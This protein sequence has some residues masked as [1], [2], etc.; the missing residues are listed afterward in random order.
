[1]SI[2]I[3]Y[4][5]EYACIDMSKSVVLSDIAFNQCKCLTGA[6]TTFRPD[7]KYILQAILRSGTAA[8]EQSVCLEHSGQLLTAEVL[9]LAVDADVERGSLLL[10]MIQCSSAGSSRVIGEVAYE[11]N[12]CTMTQIPNGNAMYSWK[13]KRTRVC[14]LTL[15]SCV[16][17]GFV[18]APGLAVDVGDALRAT[19]RHAYNRSYHI[20]QMS[21]TLP[22]PLALFRDVYRYTVPEIDSV[23]FAEVGRYITC[24][25]D[26]SIPPSYVSNLWRFA[27]AIT[28]H[29]S[30]AEPSV[31]QAGVAQASVAEPSVPSA[32]VPPAR[33]KHDWD[34]LC[35]MLRLDANLTT[36]GAD[37]TGTG[38]ASEQWQMTRGVVQALISAG[39]SDR[40]VVSDCEDMAMSII[41]LAR[42]VSALGDQRVANAMEF[43][44]VICAVRG[45]KFEASS[46]QIDRSIDVRKRALLED[47]Q[48][49]SGCHTT[50]VAISS[51]KLDALM[52][53]S[54]DRCIC[55]ELPDKCCFIDELSYRTLRGLL[56]DSLSPVS[57]GVYVSKLADR[58]FR[59][60][61]DTETAIHI[62]ETKFKQLGGVAGGTLAVAEVQ[63]ITQL[64]RHEAVAQTN[65]DPAASPPNTLLEGT[66]LV[67]VGQTDHATTAECVREAGRECD[68]AGVAYE[69]M[70]CSTGVPYWYRAAVMVV[71]RGNEYFCQDRETGILGV[72]MATLLEDIG[73]VSLQPMHRVLSTAERA[74][75]RHRLASIL[76]RP[77]LSELDQAPQAPPRVEP[78]KWVLLKGPQTDAMRRLPGYASFPLSK[79]VNINFM[80]TE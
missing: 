34:V 32:G 65:A 59:K 7:A 70:H 69:Y 47:W 20:C 54:A 62:A 73:S 52:D 48:D 80:T 30:G 50:V 2:N 41:T 14:E 31:A 66:G 38:E 79:G 8:Y 72:C 28:V 76:P 9:E 74:S 60:G 12:K 67:E 39:V 56:A 3:Y 78:G 5:K 64:E 17:S 68:R 23:P 33:L 25:T 43:I 18:L 37:R 10:R 26:S 24:P 42:R 35:N 46:V 27:E 36:Y 29:S 77:R 4:I 1:M 13:G 21:A 16:A 6:N 57:S 49:T 58:L 75:C 44:P 61:M 15:G 40:E 22:V 53:R 19:I 11:S 63:R 51:D 45:D 55:P 71:I